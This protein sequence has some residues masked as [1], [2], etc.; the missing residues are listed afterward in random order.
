LAYSLKQYP[1]T[2]L[3]LNRHGRDADSIRRIVIKGGSA[4]DVSKYMPPWGDELSHNEIEAVTKFLVLFYKD[5]DKALVLLKTARETAPVIPKKT[6]GMAVFL[7]RCAMC[8]GQSGEGN[9]RMASRI[10]PRPANLVKSRLNEDQLEQIIRKGGKAMGR[11]YQMPPWRDELSPSEIKSVV[12][13][14]M[15][16]R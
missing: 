10:T 11:S 8:H 16:I 3:T 9:G 15:S 6:I 12:M 5:N 4:R 2:N 1:D 14:L 7:G 13:F